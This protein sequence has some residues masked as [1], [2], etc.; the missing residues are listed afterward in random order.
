MARLGDLLKRT[1]DTRQGDW[2]SINNDIGIY[3]TTISSQ[4]SVI[5][6]YDNSKPRYKNINTSD[7]T[8]IKRVN[9]GRLYNYARKHIMWIDY[10]TLRKKK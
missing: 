4:L 5:A 8:K 10:N 2:V 6:I 7:M 3:I 1:N 9:D